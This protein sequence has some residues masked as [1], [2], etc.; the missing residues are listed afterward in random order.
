M[1]A[2]YSPVQLVYKNV[3]LQYLVGLFIVLKK[4]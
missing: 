1:C 3:S 4:K 2:L